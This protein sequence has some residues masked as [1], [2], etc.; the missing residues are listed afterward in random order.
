MNEN[1]DGIFEGLDIVDDYFNTHNNFT[2]EKIENLV[3]I[4]YDLFFAGTDTTAS[5]IGFILVHLINNKQ[6]QNEMYKEI[7]RVLQGKVSFMLK[8]NLFYKH[9]IKISN[10]N[11]FDDFNIFD[12]V[13]D[14]YSA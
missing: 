11:K 3:D 4:C 6:C 5:T 10:Y 12:D 8:S 2:E 13:I 9:L 14:C 1:I 7:D